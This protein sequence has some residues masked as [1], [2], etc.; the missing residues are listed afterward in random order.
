ML[1][2]FVRF[3]VGWRVI[4]VGCAFVLNFACRIVVIR[5]GPV[6]Q[7]LGGFVRAVS[8]RCGVVGGGFIPIGGGPLLGLFIVHEGRFPSQPHKVSREVSTV[9]FSKPDGQVFRCFEALAFLG[10]HQ[11]VG[12]GL[13][14]I[15]QHL[16][17]D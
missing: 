4:A 16:F 14:D 11:G 1:L 10:T 12:R 15:T 13:V 3:G 5:G 9:D 7:Y 6:R 17:G 8:L 2:C